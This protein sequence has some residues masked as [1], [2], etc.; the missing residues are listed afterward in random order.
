MVYYDYFASS[1]F[2]KFASVVFLLLL[3]VG[4]PPWGSGE[5]SSSSSSST[6]VST[7]SLLWGVS[8]LTTTN[9]IILRRRVLLLLLDHPNPNSLFRYR[10]QQEHYQQK[11]QV[12]QLYNSKVNDNDNGSD[13]NDNFNSATTDT[14]ANTAATSVAITGVTL[15]IAFDSAYGVGDLSE[16]KSER[17]TC[18]SSLDMVHRLRHDSDA[19]LVGRSTVQTDDCTLTIRRGVPL[20]N[21]KNNNASGHPVRV[22]L[23]PKL[24]LDRTKY[25]IFN[26]GLQT[27][28]YHCCENES[29]QKNKNGRDDDTNVKLVYLPPSISSTTT[30]TTTQENGEASLSSSSFMLSPRDVCDHLSNHYNIHHVMV[31]GGPQTARVFLQQD[32][33]KGGLVDR[34]I[35]VFAPFCFKQPRESNMT[36]ETFEN[37][38]LELVYEGKLGVD[39]VEHWSKPGIVWPMKNEIFKKQNNNGDDDAKNEEEDASALWP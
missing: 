23:D 11:K 8:A 9:T 24:S 6:T 36:R 35:L 5:A 14:S 37:A 30:A 38:G 18:D 19:V 17:F 2:I 26:D 27:I 28:V 25:K 33:G 1:L 4:T 32:S 15:K 29:Q 20:K 7:V 16:H 13:D 12:N 34:V 3:L 39:R 22:I 21:A 10:K 31:E